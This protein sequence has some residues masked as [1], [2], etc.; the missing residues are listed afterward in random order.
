MRLIFL[1]SLL[2]LL[3]CVHVSAYIIIGST[4]NNSIEGAWHYNE[5][6]NEKILIFVDGYF[7]ETFFDKTNKRFYY[8]RGGTFEMKNK[9]LITRIEFNT[10]S[11]DQV[12]NTYR[13]FVGINME[14]LITDLDGKNKTW[15]RLDNSNGALAGNWRITGR[16]QDGQLN[17]IRPSA[18][19]TIKILSGTRFQWAAINTETKEFFGTGGGSYSFTPG[20]YIENIEFFSRDSSRVGASLRFDDKV[21]KQEWIHTGLSTRGDKIYEIWSKEK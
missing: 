8:T 11:R 12:G 18:R 17:T 7:T 1:R 4:Q 20:T 14:E 3:L 15:Q 21:E 9:I 5:G 2:L 13:N 10:E 6:L 19:K 16:M